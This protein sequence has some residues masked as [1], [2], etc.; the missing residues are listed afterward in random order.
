MFR[1]LTLALALLPLPALA[2]DGPFAPAAAAIAAGDWP[3]ASSAAATIS[4]AA[5]SLVTWSRL[6]A[7]EGNFADYIAFLAAHPH[8]PGLDRLRGRAEE[9][10][11]PDHVDPAV[12]IAF[13]DSRSPQT[14][15]GV[16]RL[17]EALTTQ[18]SAPEAEAVVIDAWLTLPLSAEGD[19]LI[20]A[21]W[22]ELLAEAHPARAEVMLWRGQADAAARLLPLLPD[23]ARFVAAARI[24]QIRGSANR[25]D[26]IAALPDSLRDHP[27]LAFDRFF[28]LADDGDYSDAT[29]LLAA[30]SIT[31]EALG[32]PQRWASWRATLARWTMREGRPADAYAL[33]T[34]HYL[35]PE[36][37]EHFAD[38][39]W[40]AGYLALRYLDDPARAREHFVRVEAA[41]KGPIT[42]TRGAYWTGR[43]LDALG[44][45]AAADAYARAARFQTAFYGLLAAER[46]GLPYDPSIAG[47]DSLPDWRTGDLL[48]RDMTQAMLY[49]ISSGDINTSM[50]FASRYGQDLDRAGLDQLGGLLAAMD[51]PYLALIA[52]KAAADRGIIVPALYLP[53]HRLAALPDLPVAPEL[54]LSIARRESEFNPTVASP[55]GA[56]GLMQVMPGTAEEVARDLGLPYDR[57]ALTGDWEYNA[58]LGTAYLAGLIQEFGQSPVMVAAGYNAG[59]GRPR[60]WMTQRG[61]PRTGEADVIDWI[62]HIPFT[63][64]RTYVMRVTEAIPAYRA[65]LTGQTG[66]VA[67]TALLNGAPPFIRPQARPDSATPAAATETGTAPS[68]DVTPAP[69]LRPVAR[70]AG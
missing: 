47:A 42:L 19:S 24:A 43:A 46:L 28:R 26:S 17:S 70:P 33:A 10:I 45:P 2:Q 23:E 3:A 4:P 32:Q 55:V 9:N 22:G 51:Q 38:L 7:G 60:T 16:L 31:A 12:V 39:E 44:D 18:G 34:P 52:G 66:P 8:W 14:A 27:G 63:E 48:T 41:A 53:L 5:Q 49:L 13:F 50:L 21:V 40:L 36:D 62:E 11:P 64:T 67:F 37:G 57:A 20:L 54:A 58:R 65:R 15:S 29:T 30:R 25:A 1:A 61:D 68:P 59:P 69:T 56:L 35:T 6:R